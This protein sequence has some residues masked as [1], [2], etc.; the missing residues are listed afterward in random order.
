MCRLGTEQEMSGTY[1]DLTRGHEGVLRKES[2]RPPRNLGGTW[3]YRID[4]PAKKG[5]ARRQV[6]MA[7]FA[8]EAEARV[9]LVAAIDG[10]L[11]VARLMAG[12]CRLRRCCRCIGPCVER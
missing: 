8:T 4:V 7:G 5:Q 2:V 9:A 3:A 1:R 12:R 11:L 10:Y 6:Q